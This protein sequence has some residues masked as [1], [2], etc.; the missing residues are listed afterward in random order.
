MVLILAFSCKNK[1]NNQENI[2]SDFFPTFDKITTVQIDSGKPYGYFTEF[3]D[4]ISKIKEING[5][6]QNKQ[7][8]TICK[9]YY[10]SVGNEVSI[11]F[12]RFGNNEKFRN[13]IYRAPSRESFDK[14][15]DNQGLKI[16]EYYSSSV[17]T[18]ND[19]IITNYFYNE[20]KQL[21][22]E[23]TISNCKN[24]YIYSG[25]KQYFYNKNDSLIKIVDNNY[26][27]DTIIYT[28]NSKSILEYDYEKE[29][30]KK[31]TF[32]YDK[33]KNLIEKIEYRRYFSEELFVNQVTTYEYN[34]K[35]QLVKMIEKDESVYDIP[36]PS[37]RR[38]RIHNYYYK[39]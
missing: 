26:G 4:T 16:K 20:K 13:K 29:L 38:Y 14:I 6:G 31:T 19:T 37:H 33:N 25:T 8:G 5:Y 10:D 7:I 12:V 9:I 11:Q 27:F 39:K 3:Y 34:K 23:E 21:I 1:E 24:C 30:N 17:W 18:K 2:M 28:D 15:Y 22:K 35:G 32:I 36:M